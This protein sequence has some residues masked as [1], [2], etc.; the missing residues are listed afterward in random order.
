[1]SMR[2][3]SLRINSAG[4]LVSGGEEGEEE[5]E[6]TPIAAELAPDE[7]DVDARVEAK[8]Q[9]QLQK[10]LQEEIL[11]RLESERKKQVVIQAVHVD[12]QQDLLVSEP[13]WYGI[14]R[15][16]SCLL[17]V[18]LGLLALVAGVVVGVLL[19]NKS[20]LSHPSQRTKNYTSATQ[21]TFYPEVP[22][23]APT[24]AQTVRFQ[25]LLQVIGRNVSHDIGVFNDRSSPQ[26]TT[27]EWLANVDTAQ[28]DWTVTPR[29]ELVERYA[30]AYL[31]FSTN[32]KRWKQNFNFLSNGSVCEWNHI[33]S[34]LSNA[35]N[36]S[37]DTA[38]GVLCNATGVTDIRM[39]TCLL[40]QFS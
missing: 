25:T 2:S 20:S 31:Y 6:T 3:S 27:L 33:D 16:Q 13:K 26:Y 35:N 18:V 30:L 36:I 8:L 23:A 1:M 19:G 28:L 5:E 40:L 29:T 38:I 15:K 11:Q 4:E 32:G 17:R 7:A 39:G 10:R 37:L 34:S 12:E 14:R 22:T 24:I 21:V 9:A